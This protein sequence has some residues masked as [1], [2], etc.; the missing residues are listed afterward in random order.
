MDSQRFAAFF[1]YLF[2]RGIYIPP[3]SH[4]AWFMSAAHTEEQIDFTRKTILDFLRL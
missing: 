1:R 3:S 4:E 2:E